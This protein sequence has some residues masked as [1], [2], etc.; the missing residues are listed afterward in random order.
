[1]FIAGLVWA[2]GLWTVGVM[3]DDI[4]SPLTHPLCLLVQLVIVQE[5]KDTNI[6]RISSKT[7]DKSNN[8]FFNITGKSLNM[9]NLSNSNRAYFDNE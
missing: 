3:A 7:S 1:M 6:W 8:T 2:M 4:L 9:H 5:R